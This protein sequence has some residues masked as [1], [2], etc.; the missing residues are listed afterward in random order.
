MALHVDLVDGNTIQAW[1]VFAR[2]D[3]PRQLVLTRRFNK[4]PL[5]G[6]G[7]TTITYSLE[8]IANGTRI[9]VRDEGSLGRSEAVSG[10]AEHCERVLSWLGAYFNS[11]ERS[12]GDGALNE[13]VPTPRS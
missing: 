10:N 13:Y 1:G 5:P 3:A 9:T 6:E 2:T 11:S 4:H 8:P 12:F 7:E